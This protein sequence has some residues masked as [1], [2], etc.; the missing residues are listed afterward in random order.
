MVKVIEREEH[1]NICLKPAL[2]LPL[3]E[4]YNKQNDRGLY[5]P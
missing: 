5:I 1:D 3:N 4:L 2:F